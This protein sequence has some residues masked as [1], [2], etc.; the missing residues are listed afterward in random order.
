MLSL[1]IFHKNDDALFGRSGLRNPVRL[2]QTIRKTI[3]RKHNLVAKVRYHKYFTTVTSDGS[4]VPINFQLNKLD[5]K[6]PHRCTGH[7]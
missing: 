5:N 1:Q 3:A 7:L 4:D 2:I 6:L